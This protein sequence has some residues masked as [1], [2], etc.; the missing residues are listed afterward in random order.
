ML[1]EDTLVECYRTIMI[2]S[3]FSKPLL[4]KLYSA[5]YLILKGGVESEQSDNIAASPVPPPA[6]PLEL[7]AYAGLNQYLTGSVDGGT[8][9]HGNAH[10]NPVPQ[11]AS[12]PNTPAQEALGLGGAAG[13]ADGSNTI[14]ISNLDPFTTPVP[15]ASG[16]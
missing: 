16:Q 8:A 2:V 9:G 4:P 15:K 3:L 13:E 5:V 10:G 11:S 6:N 7:F 14:N 12:I 1:L